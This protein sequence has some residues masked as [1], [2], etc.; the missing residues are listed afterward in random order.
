[1]K[2]HFSLLPPVIKL[3]LISN[4]IF[5]VLEIFASNPLI[6]SLALWPFSPEL[7]SLN[8]NINSFKLWQLVSYSF[9]HGSVMHLLLNMYALWLFGVQLE[10]MWG[11][12]TFAIYYFVC[13]VGAGLVQLVVST[14]N[15]QQGSYYPTIG[16]SGGVF[17]VLLAFGLFFPNQILMLLIPPVPIKAKWFVLIYGALELWFGISGSVVGVA[18]FAHLGGMFFGLILIY[19]WKRYPPGGA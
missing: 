8:P 1:M 12:R 6:S 4:I 11:S 16:A 14:I 10:N 3:L 17:G 9:L 13:V 18:H 15:V 2:H 19:Y 7:Q 5:F